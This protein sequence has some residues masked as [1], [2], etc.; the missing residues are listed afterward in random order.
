MVLIGRRIFIG[1]LVAGV[2][3][4]FAKGALGAIGSS[5]K[6]GVLSDP[7][8]RADESGDNLRGCF[9]GLR[10]RA[11]EVI[12]IAGDVT[13]NGTVEEC[14]HFHRIW[15]DVFGAI[16]GTGEA[17]ELFLVW[18]NHDYRRAAKLRKGCGEAV[19]GRILMMNNKDSVWRMLTGQPFPGEIFSRKIRGVQFVGSH[20]GHEKKIGPW[21]RSHADTVDTSGLFV[22]VQHPHPPGTVYAG[23]S[24]GVACET[25]DLS[26]YSNCF[27]ISGHSHTNLADDAALWQGSF[28]SMGA[29]VTRGAVPRHEQ[30]GPSYRNGCFKLKRAK[31]PY[32]HMRTCQTFAGWQGS[33]MTIGADRI[34]VERIDLRTG[35]SLGQDWILPLPLETHPESPMIFS[36]KAK[37]PEFAKGAEITVKFAEGR[38]AGGE[39]EKQI[40]VSV[41]QARPMSSWGRAISNEFELF[42][43]DD[44]RTLA[45]ALALQ[46]GQGL[47]IKESMA[48]PAK[49]V[50]GADEIPA[51]MKFGVRVT[52]INAAGRRGRSIEWRE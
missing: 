47:P 6:V 21:L 32:Q 23:G 39:S 30:G 35:D 37:G 52:P 3:E 36:S 26:S 33:V 45:R 4:A 31:P 1:G 7:H 46:E 15:M 20:W 14:E 42:A 51:G 11:V 17:P 43:L 16:P 34:S 25:D 5:L 19:D 48:H 18:G 41:P 13:D 29:G 10:D 12:V 50:F 22:Y 24:S 40:I 9:K 49:C 8:L 28:T 27:A 44:G 38:N 2:G